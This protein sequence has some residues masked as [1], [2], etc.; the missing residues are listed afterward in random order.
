MTL[1]TPCA[2]RSIAALAFV[3]LWGAAATP[4][5]AQIVRGIASVID[6]DTIEIHGTRIRLHGIDT[7]E[8]DQRCQ[9]AQGISYRCGGEAAFALDDMIERRTVLCK[10]RGQDRYGRIIAICGAGRIPDLGRELVRMGWAL[11]YRRYSKEY[12]GDEEAARASGQGM[13]QGQFVP[14]WDWRKGKR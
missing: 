4:A 9:D 3:T 2:R 14:P 10:G 7:P 8:S 6:G 12:I 1:I 11:A 13:W 5:E